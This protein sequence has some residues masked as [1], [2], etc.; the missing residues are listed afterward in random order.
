MNEKK[1]SDKNTSTA[2]RPPVG[3]DNEL[4]LPPSFLGDVIMGMRFFSVLPTGSSPHEVPQMNRMVP[5]LGLISILIGLLPALVFGLSYWLG[6][7]PLLAAS[8]GVATQVF[9]T[10]AMG[11]DALA[12]SF[13][14]VFGGH[15]PA[16][17]LK[18]MKD[19]TH[20]T[21]GVLA[22]VLL[23]AA[24]LSALGTLAAHSIMGSLILWIGAQMIARQSAL[25]LVLVLPPASQNGTAQATGALSN[26]AFVVGAVI[27]ALLVF[28]FS[29]LFIG[30]VGILISLALMIIVVWVWTIIC[31]ATV[32]GYSGDLIG[33]L[34]SLVEILMLSSFILFI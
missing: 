8:F 6:L 32:G 7:P 27:C 31:K 20:G 5:A 19:S 13:D 2:S 28:I 30:L 14:G 1:Y 11:E 3:N 23:I 25:W 9:V 22:I 12:D 26:K 21:Y 33:A 29:S 18:I 24:R 10:G 15:T 17:R 4:T 34:Q 16:K